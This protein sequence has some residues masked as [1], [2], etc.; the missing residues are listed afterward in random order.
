MRAS[1]V[2]LCLGS[3]ICVTN[4]TLGLAALP[5]KAAE[6]P[7]PERNPEEVGT[8]RWG[9]DLDAALA[10][11]QNSGKPLFV[12]F[13]EVP[14][15]AGCKQFGSEVM[16]HP[17]IAEA[18]E[19]LFTPLLVHNNKGG[20]DAEILRRYEEPAWNYQVVRFLDASG[21]DI[22]PRKDRVWTTDAIATRMIAA[23]EKS[24]RSVPAYL[25][26]L[27]KEKSDGLKLAAFA[28]ACFWTGEKELGAVNGVIHTEAGF[29][30][31]HEVTQVSYDKAEISTQELIAAAEKVQC[32][33][34]VY[35]PTA[36][37]QALHPRRLQIQA[38]DGYRKAP[39]SDQKRQIQGTPL[40]VLGLRGIQATKVNAWIRT[41]AP[42]ALALLSPR[43]LAAI[44]MP[45]GQ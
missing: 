38:L 6:S 27:T 33:Q 42:K 39:A 4:G 8:V 35:L 43:Q 19:S 41:D 17:L 21:R 29:I 16:A 34:A 45:T 13:Q 28:M 14:G 9:R 15:C 24:G 26:L 25:R 18:V 37:A 40:A 5:Q 12:L 44:K 2:W 7:G 32:A 11:A 23:L 36:D 31:G 1:V 3:A 20:K 30:D 10:T 22:I